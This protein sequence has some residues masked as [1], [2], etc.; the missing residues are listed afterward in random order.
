V[1]RGACPLFEKRRRQG[2][3]EMGPS[4]GSVKKGFG[5]GFGKGGSLFVLE[6]EKQSERRRKRSFPGR[7]RE[8]GWTTK[9]KETALRPHEERK[10]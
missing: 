8:R 4:E 1:K 7:K 9:R 5:A 3:E 10:E 6:G 2:K